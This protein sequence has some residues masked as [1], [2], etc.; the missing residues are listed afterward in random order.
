MLAQIGFMRG[1][2]D[3][4]D[5][6]SRQIRRH[7]AIRSRLCAGDETGRETEIGQGRDEI[8]STDVVE[9]QGC[10]DNIPLSRCQSLQKRAE[11]AGLNGAGDAQG[12][13]GEPRQLDGKPRGHRIRSAEMQRRKVIR[14]ENAQGSAPPARLAPPAGRADPRNPESRSRRNFGGAVSI[15]RKPCSS[16]L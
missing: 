10:G 13:T 9:A 4:R 1:F 3:N 11:T 7:R 6:D 2:S 5:G 15:S 16:G 14:G 12:L 8:G